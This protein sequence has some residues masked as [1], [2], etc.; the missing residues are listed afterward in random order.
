MLAVIETEKKSKSLQVSDASVSLKRHEALEIDV[1]ARVSGFYWQ[2]MV[3]VLLGG[4]LGRLTR[5]L[6]SVFMNHGKTNSINTPCLSTW[7]QNVT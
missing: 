1:K 3:L 6:K 4:S 7:Q 2:K 5:E